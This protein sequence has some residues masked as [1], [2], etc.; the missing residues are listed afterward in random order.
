MKYLIQKG[1]KVIHVIATIELAPGESFML[2]GLM[3]DDI[4]TTIDQLPGAG[5]IPV[6]GALFRST[7]Y[8]RNETELVIS[9]TPYLVDPV[10][11]ADIKLPTDDL[12][13]ASFME[14]IFFGALGSTH[15]DKD[16]S[17]E[18]PTGF[19]TDN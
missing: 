1:N 10:K 4:S 12:R 7:A 14:S 8:K 9:V 2:A 11:G 16:P 6:L 19:M 15:G 3:R 18:G 5:D 17:L 13:P